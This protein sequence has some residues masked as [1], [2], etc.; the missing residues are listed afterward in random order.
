MDGPP[1]I[2]GSGAVDA[3]LVCICL[4]LLVFRFP[5]KAAHLA[6]TL[7][8]G[9]RTPNSSDIIWMRA[10]GSSLIGGGVGVAAGATYAPDLAALLTVFLVIVSAGAGMWYSVFYDALA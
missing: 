8:R 3:G 4:G 7:G 6:A 9:S 5:W 2:A 1:R 10:G